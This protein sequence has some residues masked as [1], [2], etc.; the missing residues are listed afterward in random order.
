MSTTPTLKNISNTQS[1][2]WITLAI[3]CMVWMKEPVWY[4]LPPL[5]R[6]DST[7]YSVRPCFVSMKTI[8]PQR[9][10]FANE[11]LHLGKVGVWNSSFLTTTYLTVDNCLYLTGEKS[12]H[13]YA[14]EVCYIS[15]TTSYFGAEY[16][17]KPLDCIHG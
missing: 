5:K 2:R 16:Y 13:A 15:W 6:I 14:I 4:I 9:L 17:I 1:K 12:L 11:Q 10:W 3:F 7:A 8:P